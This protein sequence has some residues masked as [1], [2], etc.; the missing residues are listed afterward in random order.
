LSTAVAFQP[1]TGAAESTFQPLGNNLW[2]IELPAAQWVARD[3]YNKVMG[4]VA[5]TSTAVSTTCHPST[6]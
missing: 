2:E 5:M 6:S 1:L 4:Q 3:V